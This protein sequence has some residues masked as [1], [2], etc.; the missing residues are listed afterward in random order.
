MP[1]YT[2]TN[3]SEYLPGSSGNDTILGLDG[4]DLI[5]ASGG[6]NSIDGG[7]GNDTIYG[8]DGNDTIF[9][10]HGR[11]FIYADAGDDLIL[12]DDRIDPLT[13]AGDDIEGG[14]GDDTIRA[15]STSTSGSL[16]TIRLG[17]VT[18]VETLD[19]SSATK[20]LTIEGAGLIDVSTILHYSTAGGTLGQIWG[21]STNDTIRGFDFTWHSDTI[22]G[23]GGND[24][25]KGMAGNDYLLGMAGD[26]TRPAM[27]GMTC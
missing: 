18:E 11:D 4:H 23:G 9:G 16:L 19:N 10:G 1:I 25:I 14:A 20:T 26:D 15:V 24:H 17:K 12:I 22:S 2:G 21:G 3:S 8:G 7:D 13:K 5:L 27:P 6:D